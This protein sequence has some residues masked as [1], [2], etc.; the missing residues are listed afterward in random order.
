MNPPEI[1]PLPELEPILPPVPDP[2]W[3]WWLWLLCALPVLLVLAWSVIRALRSK[4]RPGPS[5]QEIALREIAQLERDH[6]ADPPYEFSIAGCDVLRRYVEARFHLPATTRTSPE[7][8]MEMRSYS[9]LRDAER[10]LLGVFLDRCDGIKFA[11]AAAL[12]S[13]NAPLL[14]QAKDFVLGGPA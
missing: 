4:P 12:P 2:G 13:D 7:L 14:R 1:P 11:R 8:L 3:P 5:P 6:L 10:D 9:G